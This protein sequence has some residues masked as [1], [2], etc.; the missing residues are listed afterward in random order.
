MST[1]E[2]IGAVTMPLLPLPD[3]VF[4]PGMVATIVVDDPE[5][6]AA[7]DAARSGEGRLVLVP[8]VDGRYASVGVIGAVEQYEQ[9]AR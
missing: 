3:G 2:R 8:R 6:A 9:T 5:V 1:T 7:V 4:M